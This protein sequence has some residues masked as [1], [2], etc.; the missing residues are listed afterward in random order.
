MPDKIIII[1]FDSE[2]NLQICRRIRELGVYSELVDCQVTAEAI[3]KD[4][5]IKGI[6]LS[7]SPR[8]IY[9]AEAFRI[10]PAIY[11]LGLP[12]LGI[13]YGL[14]MIAYD[15]GGKVEKAQISEIGQRQVKIDH[16]NRLTEG[17]DAET[18][19]WM[20]HNDEVTVV[21]PGF[22]V[23]GSTADCRNVIVS[24]ESQALYGVQFHPEKS[25]KAQCDIIFSNFLFKICGIEKLWDPREFITAAKEKIK[26]EVG[27][28]RVLCA[29]S[30]GVDSSV[31]AVLLSQILGDQLTC[32]F[33]DHGFLRAGEAESVKETL[34]QQYQLN[35]ITIDRRSYF[36]S[37]LQGVSDPE[38]KRK[39]IGKEFI[40]VFKEESEK[41]DDIKWLA[42]GT[43]YPDIWESKTVGGQV[44]KSHHNVGGLPA[45]LRFSLLEPLKTLFKDEVRQVGRALGLSEQAVN[46]QPFP[47]PGLAV[48]VLG[49]VTA[50][51][52][53][54]LRAAD[55]IVR[56][57]ID[58]AKLP[59][60][61]QYFAILPDVLTTGIKDN[62][63]SWQRLIAVRALAS[64]DATTADWV[65]LPYEVLET[66]SRRICSEVPG[67]NRVVY[68]ITGKP[69]ATIEWE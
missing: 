38:T 42:Q 17:L 55:L 46:R 18:E 61:W 52:L 4:H 27:D 48:R 56:E 29:L 67:C 39:I 6:I 35:L 58:Q 45:D 23:S 49:E 26:A 32:M 54:I 65:R 60:A 7:G 9:A 47:G 19:F 40:N 44:I 63:R 37:K 11:D 69:P 5:S 41:L 66:I 59:E 62:R 33:V 68:D 36:L 31:V 14:Q 20:W 10:D 25:K 3:G 21:P 16:F 50:E 15:K 22:Q 53:D 12:I 13:C 51:K 8:S 2:Y 1:D 28:Q 34:K 57:V 30:G 24:S 64:Q 43:I